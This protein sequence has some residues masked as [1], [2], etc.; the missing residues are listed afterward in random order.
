[1]EEAEV[2]CQKIGIMA[3]GTLRCLGP[4]ARLKA[5]YG[6][7]YDLEIMFTNPGPAGAFVEAILPE[8]WQM[9]Q[10]MRHLK[11]YTFVPKPFQLAQ[12]FEKME[13]S[14]QACITTW[15]IHQTTLDAI[16][17]TILKEEDM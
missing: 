9:V 2:C 6:P 13:N 8:G 14:H 15:G 11:R 17:S 12:L 5:L 1:M 3:Q 10:N 4:A 16:F 7:G